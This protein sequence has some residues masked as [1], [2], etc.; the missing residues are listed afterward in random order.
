[1]SFYLYILKC[2]DN[3]YYTGHTDSLES[4]VAAHQ[5]GEVSGYTSARRPVSLMFSQEFPTREEAIRAERQVKGWSRGKKEALMRQDW[6]LLR[7]LAR[8]APRSS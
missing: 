1:M 3:S 4:R 5:R 8:S 2:S 7:E 6:D